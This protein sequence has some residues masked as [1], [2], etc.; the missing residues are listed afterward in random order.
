VL[1]Y[2]DPSGHRECGPYCDGDLYYPEPD[3]GDRVG[4]YPS[5]VG[6][7]ESNLLAELIHKTVEFIHGFEGYHALTYGTELALGGLKIVEGSTY[8]G[9]ALVYGTHEAKAA[10]GLPTHLT[11]ARAAT[12][13]GLRPITQPLVAAGKAILSRGTAVALG[14]VIGVD[15]VEYHDNSAKL[16]SALAVDTGI[17]VAPPAAGAF[18]GTIVAPGVGTAIGMGAGYV[19]SIFASL[20]VRETLID[21][22]YERLASPAETEEQVSKWVIPTGL[23]VPFLDFLH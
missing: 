16:A 19:L 15:I 10:A 12:H 6:T 9:Q 2:V 7:R 3:D 4:E 18:V 8:T 22:S 1:Q 13:A 23:W 20:F 21:F 14:I 5:H 17:T 11:H